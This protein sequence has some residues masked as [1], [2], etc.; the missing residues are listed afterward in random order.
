MGDCFHR[1]LVARWILHKPSR[2]K[3]GLSLRLIRLPETERELVG[4][5]QIGGLALQ[6]ALLP[7]RGTDF[8]H[9]CACCTER[10]SEDFGNIGHW[11]IEPVISSSAEEGASDTLALR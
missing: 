9:A 4:S 1:D 7:Y 3:V 10:I 8:V 6:T 2:L 11:D 5:N